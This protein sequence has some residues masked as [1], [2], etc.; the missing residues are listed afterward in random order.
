MSNSTTTPDV[1][2]R[3]WSQAS[4]KA[5]EAMA[6]MRE[7][8]EH[9]TSAVG[10]IANQAICDVGMKSDELTAEAGHRIQELSENLS[11]SIPHEGVLGIASQTVVE[12]IKGS[13]DYLA[14]AKLSGMT[15]DVTRIVRRY[16]IT[17]VLIAAGLGWF[18]GRKGRS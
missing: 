18:I 3:E 9:V 6:S 10:V 1:E 17:A 15:K 13:G 16:P 2:N 11:D 12:A 14:D 7:M 4:E 8:A 5:K